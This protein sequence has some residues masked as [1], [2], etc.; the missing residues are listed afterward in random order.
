M[1]IHKQDCLNCG[2]KTV[3]LQPIVKL[4]I[5]RT[6]WTTQAIKDQYP[7]ITKT[8]AK[9]EYRL[10]ENEINRLEFFEVKNPVYATAHPMK[11]F[12]LDHV[13][14]L[15]TKKWGSTEPYVVELLNFTTSKLNW[16]LDD[17]ERFK[18][19]TP[20]DFQ[21]LIAERLDKMKFNVQ[22][23]GGINSKDGGI[24][25]I[26]TPKECAFPFLLGVQVKHHRKDSKTGQREVRDLLGSINSN[27]SLFHMGMIV[28]NT[29]F[30]PDA[31]WFAEKNKKLLRLRDLSDLQRWLKD[32]FNNEFDWQEIPTEIELTSGIRVQV[33][34]NRIIADA[35]Q[36]L[37]IK[38]I[39]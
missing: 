34:S 32:D 3:R 30:S 20:E 28:T 1:A 36:N 15:S 39:R 16:L 11:L 25:I 19:I 14:A 33:P 4:P 18:K 9:S 17:L 29:S 10:N 5:C 22:L 13:E 37:L 21:Y 31:K 6:C 23:V 8:R 26:A 2:R 7:Y 27:H 35:R 24:D 12:L 38:K